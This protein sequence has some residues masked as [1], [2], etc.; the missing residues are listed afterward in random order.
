[1]PFR[2]YFS[3]KLDNQVYTNLPLHLCLLR[4]QNCQAYELFVHIIFAITQVI[5]ADRMGG[6]RSCGSHCLMRVCYKLGCS[7]I[8]VGALFPSYHLMLSEVVQFLALSFGITS[9]FYL[10]LYAHVAWKIYPFHAL[11]TIYKGFIVGYQKLE[12]RYLTLTLMQ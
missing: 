3:L 4:L 8:F 10:S 6:K 7:V 1:M 2:R 12:K 11:F 5:T 9:A